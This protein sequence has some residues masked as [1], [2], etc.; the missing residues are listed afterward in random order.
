MRRFRLIA[1]LC[2]TSLLLPSVTEK[3]GG[4][5][6]ASWSVILPRH[7]TFSSPRVADLNGDG[8]R[9]VILGT[10]KAEFEYADTAVVALDGKTGRMLWKVP[11]RDQVFGSAT[12]HDVTG[13]GVPEIFISGRSAVLLAVNGRTGKVLWEYFPGKDRTQ[14]Y[15]IGLFNFYNPQ[16]VPDQNG[17]G[18]DD[19]LVAN[20]GDVRALP[21][22]P[23]RPVGYLMLISARDGKP[24]AKAPMP[25][26]K[27]IY[28]SI[29]CDEPRPDGTIAVYY[30]TGGETL[31]GHLYRTTLRDVRRG[32]LSGSV[33]LASSPDKGFIAPPV[34]VD[35]TGDGVRDVVANAVDG[36][37][38]AVDGAT[39]QTR[40]TVPVPGTEAY[41]APAV[42][43]FNG[44][45][46]PDFF[47]SF[48]VGTWPALHWSKQLMVDGRSGAVLY[49]DSVGYRQ[50]SSPV[51]AD[52]NND[53]YDDAILSVNYYVENEFTQKLFRSMLLVF[54]FRNRTSLDFGLSDEGVNYASTPWAGDLDGDGML[55]LVHCSMADSTMRSSLKGLKINHLATTIP[56]PEAPAWGAYMGSRYDG[57]LRRFR[58][59]Q[60]PRPQPAK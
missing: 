56:V 26:G 47:V 34:L 48:S 46:V 2:L 50:S 51:V 15:R 16:V 19:L 39:H 14:A 25:D 49:A 10:G 7:N 24:I 11:A 60:S 31:G 32:D 6:P 38:L 4:D 1:C 45:A 40:W 55:D 8:V 37:L 41:S 59:P 27:E 22:D 30:G 33:R 54:D 9:D 18:T 29:V 43:N 20:G 58:T 53:G 36:R 44:D 28:M 12:L 42:G 13:D 3:P 17:D 5:P 52:V 57:V 35:I 23:E 21:H